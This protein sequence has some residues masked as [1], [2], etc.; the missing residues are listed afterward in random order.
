MSVLYVTYS[1]QSHTPQKHIWAPVQKA[2]LL[3]KTDRCKSV[4]LW[5]H[6]TDTA[7]LQ[8]DPPTSQNCHLAHHFLSVP[9]CS[10]SSHYSV[11]ISQR[12]YTDVQHVRYGQTHCCL[13]EPENKFLE[14]QLPL[15]PSTVSSRI[16]SYWVF[17]TRM[18]STS[19]HT[20]EPGHTHTL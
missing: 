11:C 16:H 4:S 5:M 8:H 14:P 3:P 7:H 20:T 10:C 6:I 13:N 18:Y 9:V 15:E 1:L 12:I 17:N 2:E 19:H